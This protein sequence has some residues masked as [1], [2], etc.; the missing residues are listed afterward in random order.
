MHTLVKVQEVSAGKK[1]VTIATESFFSKHG[2]G[3]RVGGAVVGERVG[4]GVN[5]QEVMVAS[6]TPDGDRE[7]VT[8]PVKDPCISVS[9][10]PG[11]VAPLA[12]MPAAMPAISVYKN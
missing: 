11:V 9:T 4:D 1:S 10:S 3:K 12:R 5:P 2:V 6:P 7:L 8:G